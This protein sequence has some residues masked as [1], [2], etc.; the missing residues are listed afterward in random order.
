[1]K[2]FLTAGSVIFSVLVLGLAGC[3][4]GDAEQ[5]LPKEA[6]VPPDM[7]KQM[8]TASMKP[9]TPAQIQKKKQEADKATPPPVTEPAK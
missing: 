9:T 5:G 3:E 7:Q 1:M 6:S 8:E 4:G 2:R